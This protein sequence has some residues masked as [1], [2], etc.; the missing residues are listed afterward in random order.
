M[1]TAAKLMQTKLKRV[2]LYI[3]ET[4]FTDLVG[5]KTGLNQFKRNKN[6]FKNQFDDFQKP[7]LN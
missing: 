2:S 6:Q 3:G 4:T 5:K 7:R 1:K